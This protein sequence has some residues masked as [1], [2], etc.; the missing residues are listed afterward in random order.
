M[1]LITL[2]TADSEADPMWDPFRSIETIS[3]LLSVEAQGHGQ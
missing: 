1:A 2:A 3:I